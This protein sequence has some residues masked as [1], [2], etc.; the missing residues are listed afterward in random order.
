MQPCEARDENV[1]DVDEVM[2]VRH[3]GMVIEL[4]VVHSLLSFDLVAAAALRLPLPVL[5][6]L[7]RTNRPSSYAR[8]ICCVL[9]ISTR[10]AGDAG[11]S[12][13]CSA[14]ATNNRMPTIVLR[15]RMLI[16]R[17]PNFPQSLEKFSLLGGKFFRHAHSEAHEKTAGAA[18]AEVR[19]T[20]PSRTQNGIGLLVFILCEPWSV[21]RDLPTHKAAGH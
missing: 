5:T 15:A 19:Q 7:S 17:G 13:A 18:S 12:C 11:S 8:S 6:W 14:P 21:S 1:W 16:R 4:R 9:S 3:R 20:F 2:P 10:F